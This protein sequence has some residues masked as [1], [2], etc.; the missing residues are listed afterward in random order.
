VEELESYYHA[1]SLDV[2][3]ES[4]GPLSKAVKA[5]AQDYVASRSE[6]KVIKIREKINPDLLSGIVIK[7][8]DK[9]IDLSLNQVLINLKESIAN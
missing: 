7:Y 1:G 9:K 5:W 4:A 8:G 6:A 2:V 3:V